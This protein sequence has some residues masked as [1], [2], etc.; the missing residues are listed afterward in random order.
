MTRSGSAF[1]VLIAVLGASDAWCA[2]PAA[3]ADCTGV[4]EAKSKS[5][6][7]YDLQTFMY[8]AVSLE[9]RGEE[10]F[11]AQHVA[12]PSE[13]VFGR[14]DVGTSPVAAI[15]SPVVEDVQTTHWRF[16]VSGAEPRDI[17]V[18]YDGNASLM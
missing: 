1:V 3:I 17:I 11:H 14:F 18:F 6:Q 16:H 15:Y 10:K 4:T 13:C 8:T 9:G 12:P 2:E 5:R 7:V